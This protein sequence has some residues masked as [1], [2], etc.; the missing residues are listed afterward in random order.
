MKA[1]IVSFHCV[2]KDKLGRVIS[3]SFNNEVVNQAESET[4]MLQGLIAGLQDLTQG[5]KRRI[6]VPADQAYGAY[7]PKLVFEVPRRELVRGRHL[8]IGNE[9]STKSVSDGHTRVFRVISESPEHVVLDGNHPLAGLDLVFEIEV[10]SAR[11][12]LEE[13][14]AKPQQ[15]PAQGGYIH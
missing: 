1:Q 11:D 2:L 10:T 13:D 7:D 9:V 14:L 3:S 5:E 4:D 12:A 15:L 6:F 8:A